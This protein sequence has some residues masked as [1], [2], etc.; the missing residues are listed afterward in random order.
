M[1]YVYD[2][3]FE[4]ATAAVQE[5]N[6]RIA[7]C[8]IP[9]RQELS[10]VSITLRQRGARHSSDVSSELKSLQ[11]EQMLISFFIWW[12]IVLLVGLSHE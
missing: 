9:E 12:N 3:C 11:E 6:R 4:R 8:R 2:F 1:L 5:Y 7:N 10:N